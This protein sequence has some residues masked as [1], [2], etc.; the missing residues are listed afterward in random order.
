MV[1]FIEV[2]LDWPLRSLS[3]FHT[4]GAGFWLPPRPKIAAASVRPGNSLGL[5]ENGVFQRN[6]VND[7]RSGFNVGLPLNSVEKLHFHR[8]PDNF[9]AVQEQLQFL[10]EGVAKYSLLPCGIR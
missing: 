3:G 5:G 7:R 10:A 9:R 1:S 2:R 8:G 4:A 6:W